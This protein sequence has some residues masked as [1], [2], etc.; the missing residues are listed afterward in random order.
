MLEN[1]VDLEDPELSSYSGC[2]KARFDSVRLCQ[3]KGEIVV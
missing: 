3:L 1:G 2:A